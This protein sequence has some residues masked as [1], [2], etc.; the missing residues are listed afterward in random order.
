M[1][2]MTTNNSS[3]GLQREDMAELLLTR[4]EAAR[5]LG[6]S[7]KRLSNLACQG[8]GPMAAMRKFPC[9]AVRYEWTALEAWTRSGARRAA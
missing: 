1:E 7:V 2:C 4:A 9:G 6:L 8:K 3:A 5:Y